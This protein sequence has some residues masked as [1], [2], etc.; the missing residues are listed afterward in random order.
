MNTYD[1]VI[2]GAG[3][4]GY[5]AAIK[6][7]QKGLKTA[8]IEKEAIGGVCLNWGCIPTKSLLKSAKVYKQFMHAKDYG[9]DIANNDDIKPNW[10]AIIKRKDRIVRR[11]TGG[12]KMLLKKNNVDIYEGFGE[13][14]NKNEIIINDQT[15]KTKHI[16]LSTGASPILPPIDGLKEAYDKGLLMTS[17][18]LLDIED[19]PKDLV[20]IGGG[21]I[22]LEFATIFNSFGSHVTIIEREDR[23]LLNVDDDIRDAI[24]KIVKKEKMNI[25]T[26]SSVTKIAKNEVIYK[27]SKGNEQTIKTDKVLL[28][29]G[30]KANTKGYESLDLKMNNNFVKTDDAMKTSLDNVYAI[31]DMNGKMMLAH[32]ASHQGILAINHILGEKEVMDY[33][34]VPS[35][36]YSFPEIAQIGYTEK[37]A[38]EANLD[39]KTSTFPLQANGK[40]LSANETDGFIKIIASKKYNEILGVHILADNASDLISEAVMTMKLEGTADEI[41]HAIHPH[42]TISEVF[43]EAAWGIV[44]KAIHI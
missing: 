7:A 30:M 34:Q 28:S 27:D 38:K 11:L 19:I 42:P 29:V 16:I 9:I 41:A 24:L 36:I 15:I 40:A 33:K 25:L 3:P 22:G 37:E 44:D 20:I 43:N 10:K 18:Q 35:A 14:K 6:A 21:V 31:G 13:V 26:D 5:V 4:G 17:K 8:I 23:I 2:V 39:Y 32:V 1:V 12:V